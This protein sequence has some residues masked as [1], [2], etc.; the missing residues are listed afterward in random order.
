MDTLGDR[1]KKFRKERNLTQ[2]K[3]GLE[4]GA[5]G[6]AVSNWELN[7]SHPEKKYIDAMSKFFGITSQELEYGTKPNIVHEAPAGYEIIP[8]KEYIDFLKFKA[9]KAEKEA[10]SAKN[11]EGVLDQA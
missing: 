3:L 2:A 11:I 10:E 1:I 9:E 8:T 4:I 5:K 6:T 7:I